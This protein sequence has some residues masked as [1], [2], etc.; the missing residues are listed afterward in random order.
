MFG[1]GCGLE[2]EDMG[3]GVVCYG[4]YIWLLYNGG[5]VVARYDVVAIVVKKRL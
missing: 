2:G 5:Q 4:L 3:F 1:S